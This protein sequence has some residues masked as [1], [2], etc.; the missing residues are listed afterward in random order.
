MIQTTTIHA[1]VYRAVGHPQFANIMKALGA[2]L[3]FVTCYWYFTNFDK[4]MGTPEGEK[5]ILRE[6]EEMRDEALRELAGEG[7]W[8]ISNIPDLPPIPFDPSKDWKSI[9]TQKKALS[10]TNQ[11]KS[12]TLPRIE[13]GKS[14]DFVEG[15]LTVSSLR[16][17][18]DDMPHIRALLS[19]NGTKYLDDA[20]VDIL[21]MDGK[22]KVLLRR[23]INP[24]VVSGGLF[25]DKTKPLFP[26]ETREITLD[27]SQTPPGW[28][29]QLK[30]EVIYYQLAP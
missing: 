30:A 6:M 25:G 26:G 4:I 8:L 3:V 9:A 5:Q 15:L 27:A 23:S 17:E 1:V 11:D 21:F 14:G 24:L 12:K 29:N 19:N 18:L 16:V 13:K 7:N 2:I 28:I 20:R 22:D 10:E